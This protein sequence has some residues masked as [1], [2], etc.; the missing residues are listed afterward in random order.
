MMGAGSAPRHSI[1]AGVLGSVSVDS[2]VVTAT[3][4]GVVHGVVVL[5]QARL[6]LD[7]LGPGAAAGHGTAEEDVDQQHDAEQDT[8]GDAEIRQPGWVEI[9]GQTG[10]GSD[11]R[12]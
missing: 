8:E 2:A 7:D 6:L 11:G 3:V 4:L 5:V 1:V 10:S 12:G 9:S